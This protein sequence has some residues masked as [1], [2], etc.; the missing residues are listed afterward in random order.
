MTELHLSG[1]TLRLPDGF[2]ARALEAGDAGDREAVLRFLRKSPDRTIYHAA[3]YFRFARSQSSRPDITQADLVVFSHNTNPVFAL[4]VHPR[5]HSIL[6]HYSG[7]LF[8]EGRHEPTQRRSIEALS[9]LFAANRAWSFSCV[10]AAVAPACEDVPRATLLERLLAGC[11]V[12]LERTYTR[13]VRVGEW[14]AVQDIQGTGTRH[15]SAEP[16]QVARDALEADHLATYLSS[17]RNKIRQALRNDVT[18]SYYLADSEESRLA[19]YRAFTPIHEE[20]WRRTGMRPHGLDYWLKFSAAITEGGGRDLVV[21]A[22]APDSGPVATVSFHL[23]EGRALYWAGVSLEAGQRLAANPLCLHAAL[24]ISAALGTEV[25]ELGRFIPNEPSA[26]ERAITDYKTQFGGELMRVLA[27]SSPPR[28]RDKLAARP[29]RAAGLV[30]A[31]LRSA[32]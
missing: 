15:E 2:T 29:R 23:Y 30:L 20:S 27:F 26:K 13:M 24:T 12:P 28:L 10:Q 25:V 7:V 16:L 32:G 31:S 1:A 17:T 11:E 14:S 3:P 6:T 9:E 8:P 5:G 19:A 22:S 18:I 21:L 4:P